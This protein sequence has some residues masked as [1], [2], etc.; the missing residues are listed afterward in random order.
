MRCHAHLT[1]VFRR[2]ESKLPSG[3]SVRLDFQFFEPGHDDPPL[4]VALVRAEPEPV[5]L[6]VS[7]ADQRGHLDL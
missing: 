7:K 3:E 2:G 6:H 1:D 5:G 4:L